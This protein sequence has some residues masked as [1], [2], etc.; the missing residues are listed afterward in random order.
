MQDPTWPKNKPYPKQIADMVRAVLDDRTNPSY[1]VAPGTVNNPARAVQMEDRV[2]RGDYRFVRICNLGD[3]KPFPKCH[4]YMTWSEILGQVSPNRDFESLSSPLRQ[5]THTAD[6]NSDIGTRV[7]IV[8]M[9]NS[10]LYN[11]TV[12]NVHTLQ[13]CSSFFEPVDQLRNDVSVAEQDTAGD[14]VDGGGGG[15]G[16]GNAEDAG[17][18]LNSPSSAFEIS[19]LNDVE[20]E[21]SLEEATE[22][23]CNLIQTRFTQFEEYLDR[24]TELRQCC[25]CKKGGAD[26]VFLGVGDEEIAGIE[27]DDPLC[28]PMACRSCITHHTARCDMTGDIKRQRCRD[29]WAAPPPTYRHARVV[30]LPS[31]TTTPSLH[32]LSVASTTAASRSTTRQPESFSLCRR[33]LK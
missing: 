18:G 23:C 12:H 33:R 13:H 21:K 5:W 17:A 19:F 25:M 24:P 27:W 30:A 9:L 11:F 32:P 2:C 29:R 14:A 3:F 20:A 8:M 15:G 6:C 10:F 31:H 22:Y 16:S 7:S 4:L 26:R 1:V 28:F